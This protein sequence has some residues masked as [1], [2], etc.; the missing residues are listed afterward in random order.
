MHIT[1]LLLF[2]S[3]FSSSMVHIA[4]EMHSLVNIVDSP[5]LLKEKFEFD[6]LLRYNKEFAGCTFVIQNGIGIHEKNNGKEIT[7]QSLPNSRFTT[8]SSVFYSP[9]IFSQLSSNIRKQL[10]FISPFPVATLN[11]NIQC[12]VAYSLSNRD[13]MFTFA[14]STRLANLKDCVLILPPFLLK[15]S[16]SLSSKS[17]CYGRDSSL[18]FNVGNWNDIQHEIRHFRNS[19]YFSQTIENQLLSTDWYYSYYKN[20]KNSTVYRLLG[21][22]RGGFISEYT[23]FHVIQN[24]T[25]DSIKE[26]I[27]IC[28]VSTYYHDFFRS[29][30]S[31][32]IVL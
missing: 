17:F 2:T 4:Q 12:K 27:E 16:Y 10:N 22:I 21:M 7:T 9:S 25:D 3:S 19:P 26:F 5:T 29:H 24:R 23:V 11:L 18:T 31:N 30:M 8:D 32:Y 1:P 20:D 15:P 14:D 28:T 13:S 6:I